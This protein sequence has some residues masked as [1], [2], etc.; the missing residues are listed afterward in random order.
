VY[1]Y[2]SNLFVT[3]V[4]YV[5][6][7]SNEFYTGGAEMQ[8]DSAVAVAASNLCYNPTSSFVT[9]PVDISYRMIIE[10]V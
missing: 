2:I 3:Y 6:L 9:L 7:R 8:I 10:T 1:V 5:T 4:T